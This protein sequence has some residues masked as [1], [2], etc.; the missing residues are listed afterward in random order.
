MFVLF[1]NSEMLFATNYYP[2]FSI[3]HIH[4]IIYCVLSQ[5]CVYVSVH[6]RNVRALHG[7]DDFGGM[8]CGKDKTY[9]DNV[10]LIDSNSRHIVNIPM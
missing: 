1:A 8:W 4:A 2:L 3:Y 7:A 9:C 5:P 6:N 10:S